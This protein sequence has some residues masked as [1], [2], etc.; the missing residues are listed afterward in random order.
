MMAKVMLTRLSYLLAQS[1]V[2]M[3]VL[4]QLPS[5][6]GT[7]FMEEFT[8]EPVVAGSRAFVFSTGAPL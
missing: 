8:L 2:Y 1:F 7:L 6:L 5:L 4:V 3:C